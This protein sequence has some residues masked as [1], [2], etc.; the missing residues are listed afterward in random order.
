MPISLLLAADQHS[1][2]HRGRPE[3]A[4]AARTTGKRGP[5]PKLQQQLER[6]IRLPKA[7]QHYVMQMIDIVL[8]K[9]QPCR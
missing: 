7:Q 6:I 8:Q 3:G 9:Q 5:A 4:P 1:R 2:R